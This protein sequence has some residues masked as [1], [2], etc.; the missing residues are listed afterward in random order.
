M[1]TENIS[2]RILNET[3]NKP[4]SG[5]LFPAKRATHTSIRSKTDHRPLAT[6]KKLNLYH[7]LVNVAMKKT[8]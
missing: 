5:L 1:L 7:F 3:P 6:D 4:S 2:F 8:S